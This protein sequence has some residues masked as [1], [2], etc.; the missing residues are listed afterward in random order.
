MTTLVPKY[1]QGATGAVNRP[2]NQ[3]LAESI[4]V[5]DFGA[6]PT[7]VADSTTA[8]QNAL[9]AGSGKGVYV[10]AGIYKITATLKITSNTYFYGDGEASIITTA[11]DIVS[12]SSDATVYGAFIE[13]LQFNNSF[14]VSQVAG[15]SLTA[16]LTSGSSVVPVTSTAGLTNGMSIT[17]TGIPAGS[18]IIVS[19]YSTAVFLRNYAG[20][21]VNATASGA[22]TLSTFFAQ[23]QTQYH[24]YFNNSMLLRLFNITF[25]TSFTDVHYSP[26]NHAG[27][28]LDRDAGGPSGGFS[29]NIDGCFFHHAQLLVGIS[30]SNVKNTIIWPNPFDFGLKICA[31]GNTVMGCNLSAGTVNGALWTTATVK[32]TNGSSNHTIVGNNIDGGDVWYTSY[33]AQFIQPLNITVV[34]NRFNNTYKGGIYITDTVYSVITG[35]TFLNTNRND[36]LYSDI[37]LVNSLFTSNFNTISGN[38]FAQS[39]AKSLPGYAVKDVN[40]GSGASIFNTYT[41]NSVSSNYAIPAI[42]LLEPRYNEQSGNTGAATNGVTQFTPTLVNVT[43]GNGTLTGYYQQL[44]GKMTV[45]YTLTF[46]STTTVA[47]LI[48]LTLPS[49]AN[50]NISSQGSVAGFDSS[51]SNLIAGVSIVAAGGAYAYIVPTSAGT[52][53]WNATTPWTW[54]TGDTINFTLTYFI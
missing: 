46:G 39:S 7:G 50:A 17:G 13:N 30:D 18:Y 19:N 35:N 14:P 49:P 28:W 29:A 43:L 31:P 23:G 2:F 48:G 32:E 20:V 44:S 33:G 16:T 3:K 5:L 40:G 52:A 45:S 24:M 53:Y 15:P 51:T 47:G 42:L 12:L 37:E 34:G 9:L 1:D 26:N 21:P 6:D 36:S 22:Q 11:L 41:G 4:S 25:T 54:A 27:L 10:P 38:S 8:I